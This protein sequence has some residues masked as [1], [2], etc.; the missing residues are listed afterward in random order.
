MKLVRKAVKSVNVCL[1]ITMVFLS[2]P[3]QSVLAAIIGTEALLNI[4]RCNEARAF[5]YAMLSREDVQSALMA[6]GI[7][8]K[9]AKNRVD[10][11]SDAEVKRIADKLDRLPQGGAA[12]T[13]FIVAFIAFFVLMMTD[14]AGH[15]DVFPFVKKDGSKKID[16]ADTA[17]EIGKRKETHSASN[18]IE[19]RQIENSIIYFKQNSNALSEQAITTLNEIYDIMLGNPEAELDIIGFTDA[20]PSPAYYKVLSENR[21][22]AIK[23]YLVAKGLKPGRTRMVLNST[24]KNPPINGVEIRINVPP[25]GE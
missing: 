25:G 12:V 17:S 5:F 24:Q 6:Q 21:V 18:Q 13:F 1:A 23:M 11:L 14:I 19:P 9:E 3:D 15:T 20:A 22:Y 4:N 8:P 2:G 10:C 7:D 16:R